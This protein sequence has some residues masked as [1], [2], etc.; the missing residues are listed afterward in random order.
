MSVRACAKAISSDATSATSKYNGC[1]PSLQAS[2]HPPPPPAA[3]AASRTQQMSGASF[4]TACPP[5]RLPRV[6]CSSASATVRTRTQSTGSSRLLCALFS[7][8]KLTAPGSLDPVA[9]PTT[10]RPIT[11]AGM[12]AC[13]VGRIEST[14]RKTRVHAMWA[15]GWQMKAVSLPVRNPARAGTCAHCVSCKCTAVCSHGTLTRPSLHIYVKAPNPPTPPLSCARARALS[16][17]LSRSLSRALSLSLSRT[18]SH[19]RVCVVCVCVCVSVCFTRTWRRGSRSGE[20]GLFPSNAVFCPPPLVP[21]YPHNKAVHSAP[22]SQ[23]LAPSDHARRPRDARR[24]PRREK[25]PAQRPAE[26]HR[27]HACTPGVL[28]FH[29]MSANFLSQISKILAPRGSNSFRVA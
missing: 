15:Q 19:T 11:A 12:A 20:Q 13:S 22:N 7:C 5:P 29:R 26:Q 9:P 3:P 23:L 8:A 2:S 21:L 27:R 10:P 16:L 24:W 18:H 17:S 14:S 28:G 1:E 6:P 4:P 25:C